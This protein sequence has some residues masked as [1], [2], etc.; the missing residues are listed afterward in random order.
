MTNLHIF[1]KKQLSQI[2]LRSPL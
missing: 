1:L 2:V